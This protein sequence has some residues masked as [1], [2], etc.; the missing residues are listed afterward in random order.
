M[1]LLYDGDQVEFLCLCVEIEEDF[2]IMEG[3]RI[4]KLDGFPCASSH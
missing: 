1:F 2:I 3:R 4:Y